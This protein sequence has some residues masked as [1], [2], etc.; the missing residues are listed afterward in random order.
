MRKRR[1]EGDEEGSEGQ[2]EEQE[3]NIQQ[4]NEYEDEYDTDDEYDFEDKQELQKLLLKQ[5]YV[6]SK[7]KIKDSNSKKQFVTFLKKIF[8]FKFKRAR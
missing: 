5:L 4:D 2:D 8:K 3:Q 6:L 1:Y 7:Q